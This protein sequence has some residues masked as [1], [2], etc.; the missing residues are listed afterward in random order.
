MNGECRAVNDDRKCGQVVTLC[1]VTLGIILGCVTAGGQ[2]PHIRP[3]GNEIRKMSTSKSWPQQ[4]WVSTN[5]VRTYY[6]HRRPSSLLLLSSSAHFRG[7]PQEYSDKSSHQSK[8]QCHQ[9]C[10]TSQEI[11]G[12]SATSSLS[13]LLTSDSNV[14]HM[15]LPFV[16]L[17]CSASRSKM[18]LSLH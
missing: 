15:S 4:T 13:S 2:F 6:S 3:T 17:E 10:V 18:R 9:I 7:S 11:A 8:Y 14:Y 12:A 5:A 16:R 1:Q